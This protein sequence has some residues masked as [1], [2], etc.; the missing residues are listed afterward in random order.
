M[1]LDNDRKRRAMPIIMRIENHVVESTVV[2]RWYARYFKS[3]N[4]LLTL[5]TMISVNVATFHEK[6]RQ[7][8]GTEMQN[9]YGKVERVYRRHSTAMLVECVCPLVSRRP[10]HV[11]KKCVSRQPLYVRK[12]CE[13]TLVK[14]HANRMHAPTSAKS[15]TTCK[16]KVHASVRGHSLSYLYHGM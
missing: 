5:V 2:S 10:L 13:D 3:T 9:E 15:A 16:A 14:C 7:Q 8:W 1:H 11:R 4:G 6:K 12:K